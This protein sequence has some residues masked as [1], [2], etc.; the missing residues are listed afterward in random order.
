MAFFI[1][2]SRTKKAQY[3]KIK[4]YNSHR[5]RQSKQL[6]TYLQKSRLFFLH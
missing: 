2:A 5:F 1:A 6:E 4:E 3:E